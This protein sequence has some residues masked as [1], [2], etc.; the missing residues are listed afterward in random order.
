MEEL[1]LRLKDEEYKLSDTINN[2][3]LNVEA[4][5]KDYRLA[6]LNYENAK[7]SYEWDKQRFA[8]GRISKLDLLEGELNYL[9]RE[10]EKLSAAY[11]L[12]LAK[13]SLELTQE[14]ILDSL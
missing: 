13:R 3:L 1:R 12:Y 9:N 8:L 10:N 2:L 5:Q 14:G 7:Q 4:K 6:L 11:D